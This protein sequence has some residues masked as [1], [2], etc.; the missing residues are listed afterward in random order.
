[1]YLKR[2][3]EGQEMRVWSVLNPALI[4]YLQT[5]K[6]LWT[7]QFRNIAIQHFTIGVITQRLDLRE[8]QVLS[9]NSSVIEC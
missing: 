6:F 1:M 5:T 8:G 7:Q 2:D 9:Y 3:V 4:I